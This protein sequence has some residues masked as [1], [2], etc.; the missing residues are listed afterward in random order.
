MQR[1]SEFGQERTLI[2]PFKAPRA[3]ARRR[4]LLPSVGG[5]WQGIKDSA[6]RSRRLTI[7]DAVDASR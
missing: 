4:F 3:G 7:N 1:W 2:P 6:Y 5:E